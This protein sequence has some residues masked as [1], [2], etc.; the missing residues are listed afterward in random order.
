MTW[1]TYLACL[2]YFLIG[3]ENCISS[4]NIYSYVNSVTNGEN[5]VNHW[6]RKW[7]TTVMFGRV[8]CNCIDIDRGKNTTLFSCWDN[9]EIMSLKVFSFFNLNNENGT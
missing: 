9:E 4:S 5:V 1:V 2:M 8:R 3:Y 7:Y 6:S